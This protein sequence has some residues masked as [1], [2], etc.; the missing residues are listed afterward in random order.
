MYFMPHADLRDTQVLVS[1][2]GFTQ[3]KQW[4]TLLDKL[5]AQQMLALSA[6]QA[7]IY[8]TPG[9]IATEQVVGIL[10]ESG[11]EVSTVQG[12]GRPTP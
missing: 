5:K 3:P 6:D 9:T 10:T 11:F 4:R 7:V 8:L 12:A 1:R 2:F